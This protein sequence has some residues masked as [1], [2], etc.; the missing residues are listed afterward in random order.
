M[1]CDEERTRRETGEEDER[2]KKKKEKEREEREDQLHCAGRIK[3]LLVSQ[4][5]GYRGARVKWKKKLQ[6]NFHH[7]FSHPVRESERVDQHFPQTL[8][9]VGQIHPKWIGLP[10]FYGSL[11]SSHRHLTQF[12]GQ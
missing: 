9:C 11:P 12:N 7:I 5:Q 2:E 8:V 1:L 10:F 4:V 6:F 3:R